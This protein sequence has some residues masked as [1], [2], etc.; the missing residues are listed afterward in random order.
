MNNNNQGKGNVDDETKQNRNRLLELFA[1]LRELS[2]QYDPEKLAKR[3]AW[4]RRKA[5]A[6]SF[7]KHYG[8]DE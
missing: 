6:F 2:P 5:S 8:E 3:R 7:R 4:W 1:K